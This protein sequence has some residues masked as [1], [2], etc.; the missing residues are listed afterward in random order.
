MICQSY[1]TP[2]KP[3]QVLNPIRSEYIAIKHRLTSCQQGIDR[4][5]VFLWEA[6]ESR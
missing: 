1:V 4:P 5:N 6:V 3:V 2:Q